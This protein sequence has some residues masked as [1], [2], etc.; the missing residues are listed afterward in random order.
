LQSTLRRSVFRQLV[1][2]V[3]IVFVVGALPV[4]LHAQLLTQHVKGAVGLKAGSQPPPGGY[5][6]LPVF[7]LYNTSKVKDRNG[8]RLPGNADLTSTFFG[9]GYS[10]VTTKKIFGG[11]YG[12]SVLFPVGANNRIQGTEIDANPGAGLTDSAFA[13]ISLGWH[14]S[15]A[16]V[17]TAFNIY[18]PTGK[19]TDGANDN[20]G[21]GMWGFEPAVGTTVYLDGKKQYHAAA[22]LSL[23]VQSKKEDSETKVGNQM[24]IDGGVGVDLL[25]GGLSTGLAYYSSFKVSDDTIEG[26]PGILIRGRNK[27]FGLGPEATLAIAAKNKVYGFITVRYF[28]EVYARTTTQGSSLFIAGTLLTKPITV[29]GT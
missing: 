19:Y 5:V 21:L 1:R 9:A 26:L 15:R 6:P 14:R 7:Y 25:K 11:F 8:D 24:N 28:W 20:T 16:D 29:P 2:L 13:P 3:L 22:E 10:H 27:V 23:N 17:I 12:F 18:I 4:A